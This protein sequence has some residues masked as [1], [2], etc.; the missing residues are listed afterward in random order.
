MM[1]PGHYDEMVSECASKNPMKEVDI[2]VSAVIAKNPNNL[3][4][5]IPNYLVDTIQIFNAALHSAMIKKMCEMDT[6]PWSE[7]TMDDIPHFLGMKELGEYNPYPI[8]M[9]ACAGSTVLIGV[10][11]EHDIWVT[12]LGDSEGCESTSSLMD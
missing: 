2:Q 11:I 12:S 7:C 5:A 4:E 1:V 3:G 10:I 8:M 9:C 6:R